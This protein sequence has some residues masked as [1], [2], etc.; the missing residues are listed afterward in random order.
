MFVLLV[1]V[2][3]RTRVSSEPSSSPAF[4]AEDLLQC[5]PETPMDISPSHRYLPSA[6]F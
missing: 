1:P 6:V 3:A 5:P 2:L 4:R